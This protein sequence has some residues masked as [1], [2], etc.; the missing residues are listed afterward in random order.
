MAEYAYPMDS[1]VTYNGNGV[2]SFD[3]AVTSAQLRGMISE[4]IT[5]GVL[6]A[7]N[8]NAL[9]VIAN[10]DNTVT[11]Q[12]GLCVINGAIKKFTEPTIMLRDA[13]DSNDNSAKGIAI[14]AQLSLI[15]RNIRLV[16]YRYKAQSAADLIPLNQLIR[17]DNIY[18]IQLANIYIAPGSVRIVQSNITDT[19]LNTDRCGAVS[20]I[21]QFDTTNLYNQIQSDLASFKSTEQADFQEWFKNLQ[22]VLDTNTAAHLQNEIDGLNN[23]KTQLENSIDTSWHALDHLYEG[24]DLTVVFASEIANYSD[25]WAWIQARLN[26][27]NLRGIHV[28]DYIPINIVAGGGAP[29]Q[30]HKA[31]IAGINTYRRTGDGV[32]EVGYHIDWITRDCYSVPVKWNTENN[33]NGNSSNAQPFLASNLK[34]WL[35]TVVYPRLETKLKNVIKPKRVLAPTRYQSGTTLTDDNSWAWSSFDKLWVP[36]ESEVFDT[37]VWSTKGFGYGQAVQYPIFANSYEHRM[38]G[39]GP[40]G[41]RTHWWLASAN[42]GNTTNAVNVSY[43]GY[44]IIDN[45]SNEL[46]VPLCFRTME[47]AS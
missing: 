14:C 5:N 9:R 44:S 18:A 1:K 11:V 37:P 39:A 45:A 23:S 4:I 13:F 47:D 21:S 31:E 46:L 28:A 27:H 15:D 36:F 35:D 42:S 2:P 40:D 41:G 34:N 7:N 33:N 29:A 24:R 43:N 17:D 16:F 12:P 38:K 32:N 10:G 6:M 26:N 30:V 8:S 20:S 22:T 25:E 19:R 3:R